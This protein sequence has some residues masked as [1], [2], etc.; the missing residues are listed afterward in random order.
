VTIAAYEPTK[1]PN[2]PAYYTDPQGAG[3]K[4][5]AKGYYW[6]KGG[7]GYT[8]KGGEGYYLQGG[9]GYKNAKQFKKLKPTTPTASVKKGR[10]L[11]IKFKE[12]ALGSGATKYRVYYRVKG[13]SKWK[14]KT[15]SV[16]VD[17]T[18]GYITKTLTKLKKGKVYQVKVRAY[19][20][21]GKAWTKAYSKVK[22]SKK[23]K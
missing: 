13:T 8:L 10:K 3:Y 12:L 17:A 18:R 5:P 15:Y 11:T 7:A 4:D 14:Y 6:K 19:R 16:K 22:T 1:D 20:A 21:D 9:D 2:H 23:I